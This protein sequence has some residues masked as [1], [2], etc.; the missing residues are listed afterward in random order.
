MPDTP[1]QASVADP[2]GPKLQQAPDHPIAAAI[3]RLVM[4]AGDVQLAA[5]EAITYAKNFKTDSLKRETEKLN[6]NVALATGPSRPAAVL[7]QIEL[8]GGVQRLNRI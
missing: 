1:D 6:E 8:L 5:R 2:P 4:R 3:K 7:A